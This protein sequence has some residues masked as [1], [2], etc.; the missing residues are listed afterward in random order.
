VTPDFAMPLRRGPYSSSAFSTALRPGGA[1]T[2][3][4]PAL[5]SEIIF[6]R[7]VKIHVLVREVR[8]DSA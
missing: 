1:G 5:R 3:E 2:F 7:F 8:E 6:K 4:E